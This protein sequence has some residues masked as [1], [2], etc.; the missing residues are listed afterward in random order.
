MLYVIPSSASGAAATI[1]SRSFWSAERR[2][3]GR[4]SR[5][6]RRS[7]VSAWSLL[8]DVSPTIMAAAASAPIDTRRHDALSCRRHNER[9]PTEV[10]PFSLTAA[11]VGRTGGP[12]H[13]RSRSDLCR[14]AFVEGE[15]ADL[16]R[17]QLG[18][19]GDVGT[20]P[21]SGHVDR[22]IGVLACLPRLSETQVLSPLSANRTG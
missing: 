2:S 16:T 3:S 6:A 8:R 10:D 13:D 19:V 14:N 4:D 7:S 18:P 21:G 22:M 1:V 17:A 15:V 12:V 9:G 11:L 20:V 5:Y